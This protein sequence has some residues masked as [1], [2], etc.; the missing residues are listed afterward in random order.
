MTRGTRHAHRRRFCS[1]PRLGLSHS[2]SF[3]VILIKRRIMGG[4]QRGRGERGRKLLGKNCGG[5]LG[6]CCTYSAFGKISIA[7]VWGEKC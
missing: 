3:A 7:K 5:R 2:C 1:P 4:V 6:D